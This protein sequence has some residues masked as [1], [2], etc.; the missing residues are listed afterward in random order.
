[1]TGCKFVAVYPTT[2]WL[3]A[4]T[5]FHPYVRKDS[6]MTMPHF[7]TFAAHQRS[8]TLTGSFALCAFM[9]VAALSA[10]GGGGSDQAVTASTA[11]VTGTAPVVATTPA[12]PA[13]PGTPAMPAACEKTNA[14]VGQVATLSTRSHGVSGKVVVLDNCTLEIRNFNYDGG[15]LS[16]VFVYGGKAGNYVAGFP[17]GNNLRG[18]SFANQTLTINLSAGDLDRMD[19]VSI[20]CT[21]A[22]ANFGDGLFAPV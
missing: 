1:M 15:G 16:R 10:C 18:T 9:T 14:K 8:R 3:Q 4:Q 17:I 13:T 22:N 2:R 20:W 12:V 6:V 21:D 7:Q 19:G 5:T 11:P